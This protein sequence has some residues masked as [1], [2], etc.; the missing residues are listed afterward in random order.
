MACGGR[1][2]RRREGRGSEAGEGAG[3]ALEGHAAA[4]LPSCLAQYRSQGRRSRSLLA[5]P[6]FNDQ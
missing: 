5:L 6:I 4:W 2:E 3:S 1:T